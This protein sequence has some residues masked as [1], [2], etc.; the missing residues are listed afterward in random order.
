MICPKCKKELIKI[1]NTYQCENHHSYDISK[2]GYINLLLNSKNSGDNKEMINARNQ[3]LNK[4]YYLPLKEKV[5]NIIKSLNVKHII[6]IGCGDGYFDKG[7]DNLVGVDISKEAII[8]ASKNNKK[9]FY[10]VSS[11]FNLPFSDNEF[12]LIINIFA[13]HDEKEFTRICKKYILKVVPNKNHLIE[14]KQ[15]LYN[16]VHLKEEKHLHFKEFKEIEEYNVTYQVMIED[17]YEL[18][19]MTPY[20][21]T[22]NINKGLLDNN[23]GTLITCDFSI[24]LYEKII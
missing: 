24:L 23:K 18:V 10:I 14:L 13:P 17:L 15:L 8:K 16:D 7:I 6:D 19:L 4:N 1:A 9:G 3:F 11:G 5:D 22:S 20:F 2:S 21:Y 12:D